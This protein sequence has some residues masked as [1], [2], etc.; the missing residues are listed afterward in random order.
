LIR[1]SNPLPAVCGFICHHPCEKACLNNFLH[2]PVSLRLLKR[3]LAEEDLQRESSLTPYPKTKKARVLIV[4]SGPAGLTAAHDLAWL[5]YPV[6]LYESLPVLG[7]MLSVGIPGFRLPRDLLQ[8]EIGQIKERGVEMLTR[9]TFRSQDI[10]K[11]LKRLGFQAAFLAMGAHKS[12]RLSIPGERLPGVLAGVELLR[13]FNLGRKVSL[14][15]KVVVLGGGNVAL[16]VA[17]AARR[18]GTKEVRIV[19][20]RSMAE[21][22]AIPEEVQTAQREG[23]EFLFLSV[24]VRITQSKNNRLK[25]DCLKTRLGEA[26]ERGRRKPIPIEGSGFSL[27][28]DSIV[29]AVGQEVDRKT[30][31]GLELHADGTIKTDPRTGQTSLKGIF[32]GGDAVTGPAWAIEAIAAGKKGAL[33]IDEYLS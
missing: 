19:Y 27:Y 13:K 18:L 30:I 21:M 1:Q 3:F 9:R 16:D 33:A 7:G 4:G 12:R 6:T 8:K 24:P 20:R 22:P 14:G 32:A 10:P 2:K 28:A 17:R 26:D 25:L 15:E 5:G 23:I 31:H 11:D 29:R